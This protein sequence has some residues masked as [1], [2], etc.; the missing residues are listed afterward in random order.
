[1]QFAALFLMLLAFGSP[2]ALAAPSICPDVSQGETA[3]DCPWAA[4]GRHWSVHELKKLAPSVYRQIHQDAL[5]SVYKSLWGKSTDFDELAHATILDPKILGDLSRIMKAPSPRKIGGQ[6]VALAGLAH[7]YGY[8]FSNLK[9]Q[10][11][12]KRQR[13]VSAQIE[14]GLGLTPGVLGPHAPSSGGGTLFS[15]VTYFF[16]RIAF[17]DDEPRL[18]DLETEASAV[19][20]SIHDFKYSS[21]RVSRLEEI[22]P[23]ERVILHTDFVRFPQDP[24]HELLVYSVL[25]KDSAKL[26]T[27]FSVTREYAQSLLNPDEMGD[28]RPIVTRYNAFVAGVSG[29]Q[30][31][32]TRRIV[33][34]QYIDWRKQNVRSHH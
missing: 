21:L 31:T 11:G 4:I 15:N 29:K 12:F 27:G 33:S 17:R 14:K 5:L 34:E 8:L 19:A 9:T 26:I 20:T 6:T 3:L 32:G 7:T 25:Q 28:D 23:S 16:G 18:K 22:I 2:L 13:W 30:F 24:E 1:M 10:F